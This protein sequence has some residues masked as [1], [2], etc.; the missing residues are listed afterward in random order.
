VKSESVRQ[1]LV[2]ANRILGHEGILDAYGHVSVRHPEISDHFLLCRARSPENVEVADVL[3][4]DAEGALVGDP[5]AIPYIERFI[6]AAVYE[7]RPDVDAV[8]HNHAISIL[9]FSISR[10][11]KLRATINASRLFGEGVPVWDIADGF[12]DST[13]MLVANMEQG[14]SLARSLGPAPL[15]L[16]RG[17]GAVVT[18]NDLRQ[19][20]YRA[21]DMDRGA[22]A[23]LSVMTLGA[24]RSFTDAE[25]APHDGL[26]AGA[27]RD[28]RAWEY[29]LHRAGL[30]YAERS[31]D[32]EH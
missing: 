31:H 19:V 9:P 24:T 15:A 2:A 32:D 11:V 23:Q 16:M 4:F 18:G 21:L 27:T 25:L 22:R 1:D 13:S 6:H 29:L 12:G 20:V 7:A 10:Q 17:H 14:R 8:C 30:D 26:P 5:G 28:D 3:E